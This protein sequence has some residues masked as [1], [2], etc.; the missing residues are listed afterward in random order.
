MSNLA[1]AYIETAEFDP[2]RDEGQEYAKRLKEQ[3]VEVVANPTSGTI[4]GYEMAAENP[5]AIRSL[6]ER[7]SFLQRQLRTRSGIVWTGVAGD[8]DD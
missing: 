7:I 5:E 4:H 2:L 1:A 8:V 3:G 6:N